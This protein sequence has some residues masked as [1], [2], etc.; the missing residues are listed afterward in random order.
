MSNLVLNIR[1]GE[2]H[3][4]MVRPSGWWSYLRA[5]RSPI[6][7][8]HN[9]YQAVLRKKNPDWRWFEIL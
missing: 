4:Q 8:S 9:G 1:F 3:L 5:R 7:I 6:W 2:Y